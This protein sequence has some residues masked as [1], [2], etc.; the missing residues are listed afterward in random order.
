MTPYRTS[1]RI[2]LGLI[3]AAVAIALASLAFT[4]R[5]ADRLEAQ[6]EQAV[7]VWA[8]AIEYQYRVSEAA[9]GPG[10]ERESAG[11]RAC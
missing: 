7:E 4:Q 1:T 2:K 3:V 6:D 10:P 8:R 5:L 11:E 9:Q